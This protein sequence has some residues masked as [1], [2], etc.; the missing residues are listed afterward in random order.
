MG[1]SIGIDEVGRGA[2][3]GPVVVGAVRID[4]DFV[5]PRILGARELR[6]SKQHNR[7]DH[8]LVAKYVQESLRWGIGEA[9]VDE[10]N[11][12]GLSVALCL[13]ADRALSGLLEGAQKV[14]ADAG[15]FHGRETEVPTMRVIRGDE[16][17][18]AIT[19]ASH[20]AKH[21]RDSHMLQLAKDYPLYTWE[22]NVGYGTKSHRIAILEHGKTI[23]H[24]EV[25]LRKL[26]GDYP[27]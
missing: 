16:T 7:A 25:F 9:S 18:L 22:T 26:M 2:L 4:P 5:L 21:Y 11:E 1:D 3:A 19:L 24:R 13:A 8:Q 27:K 12:L 6:D 15:L 20:L 14:V 23:H 17:E 10:I